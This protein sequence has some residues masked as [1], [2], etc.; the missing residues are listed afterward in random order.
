M[1]LLVTG[2]TGF[3][4]SALLRFLAQK[5]EAEITALVHTTQPDTQYDRVT[6]ENRSLQQINYQWLKEQQF[7]HIFHLARIPG[8]RWGDIGRFIA[9]KE[10]QKANKLL[11]KA[12]AQLNPK[13]KLI[14]LSGSL[15]YGHHPGEIVTEEAPLNPTGFARQ[16]HLTE[17]PILDAILSGS[18]NIMMLRAPWIIG[19]GS[20]FKQLYQD[21]ITQKNMLP[22]YGNPDRGMSVITVEDCAGMMWHYAMNAPYGKVYNI[23][24]TQNIVYKDFI[25][26]IN[27]SAGD[28]PVQPFTEKQMKELYGKTVTNSVCCEV[29]LGTKHPAILNSYSLQHPRLDQY[30]QGLLNDNQ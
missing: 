1:R 5:K 25:G 16:Y 4:G 26:L 3:T 24:G 22:L 10:G 29:A 15:M 21:A 11:L 18:D 13:P 28:I 2:A 17:Q 12:I 6:Y 20:W 7:D 19:N 27:E 9:A 30:I 8:K 23:Y 14:Y